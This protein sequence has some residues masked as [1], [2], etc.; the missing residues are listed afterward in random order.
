VRPFEYF[1]PE[2]LAAALQIFS[3]FGQE[4]RPIAGGTDL[5]LQMRLGEIAPRAIVNLTR[6]PE[7]RGSPAPGGSPYFLAA[8]TT[9]Q[10]LCQSESIRIRFPALAKAAATMASVQ[11]R[12]LATVGGNLCN[13]APSADLA[14]ILLALGA[15]ARVVGPRGE[16][17]VPLEGFF[18]GPGRTVLAS[19]ELLLGLDIPDPAGH[20]LYLKHSLRTFMDI[21]I[22]G[23]AVSLQRVDG[24]CE[25]AS[26]SMGA[27]APT[28]T[29][30]TAAEAELAGQRL[31]PER[32][33][34]A[35]RAAAAESRPIDDMRASAWY[36]RRMVEVLTRRALTTL[37][38]S[39]SFE[40][41]AL[42]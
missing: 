16:R 12:N 14:A 9:L 36:R 25:S 13:A 26:I 42:R 37:A 24:R 19:D 20:S 38:G 11:V 8:L 23:V 40:G 35:A 15:I 7:L 18:L 6:V 41:E 30:A 3:D 27:V 2:N 39:P 29:R 1:A 10:Q 34:R 22:V 5:L 21:A 28:P 17:R 4:A 31:T 33:E 32:I